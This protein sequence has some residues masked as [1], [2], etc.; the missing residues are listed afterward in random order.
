MSETSKHN[1]SVR[2]GRS[3]SKRLKV[4]LSMDDSMIEYGM[5]ATCCIVGV[6]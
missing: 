5:G 1:I 4:N 3:H 6:K 2:A